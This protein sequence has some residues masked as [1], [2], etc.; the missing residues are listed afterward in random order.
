MNEENQP[1]AVQLDPASRQSKYTISAQRLKKMIGLSTREIQIKIHEDM[2]SEYYNFLSFN[3]A[4]FIY[5]LAELIYAIVV[6]VPIEDKCSG[7]PML[8][9]MHKILPYDAIYL[10]LVVVRSFHIR[11]FRKFADYEAQTREKYLKE[12]AEV[13]GESQ[14]IDLEHL[15]YTINGHFYIRHRIIS[16]AS[17]VYT[18]LF[19]LLSLTIVFSLKFNGVPVCDTNVLFFLDQYANSRLLCYLIVS[20]LLLLYMFSLIPSF[21]TQNA[22]RVRREKL[23]A[24]MLKSLP[25]KE[26]T[27]DAEDVKEC[28]ICLVDYQVKD[29]IVTLK[30]NPGHYFHEECI[31]KW[32]KKTPKCPTCRESAIK[33][34]EQEP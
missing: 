14:R 11:K 10:V 13:D 22:I 27:G 31:K 2:K 3:A 29:K 20:I 32:L 5:F 23:I 16:I 4:C 8:D 34:E 12:N 18:L 24:D 33:E 28:V 9:F 25:V 7:N 17:S 1:L 15:E 26:Y 21:C 30:C 19:V 6:T